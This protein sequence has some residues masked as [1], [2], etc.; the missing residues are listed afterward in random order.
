[1]PTQISFSQ[2]VDQIIDILR[3]EDSGCSRTLGVFPGFLSFG[4]A[5]FCLIVGIKRSV[6][7]VEFVCTVID[8]LF[9]ILF[10]NGRIPHRTNTHGHQQT[11][12]APV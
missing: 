7:L 9:G 8:Q 10:F 11:R 1:M 6:F 5:A 4:T 2:I 12:G 3:N